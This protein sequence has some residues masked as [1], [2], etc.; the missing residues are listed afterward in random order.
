MNSK[1]CVISLCQLPMRAN[2]ILPVVLG[3]QKIFQRISRKFR[4]F[5]NQSL[6]RRCSSSLPLSAT[7]LLIQERKAKSLIY[8]FL[9]PPPNPENPIIAAMFGSIPSSVC[10]VEADATNCFSFSDWSDR[11]S[12]VS[13]RAFCC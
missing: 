4:I 10:S 13:I 8:R 3:I 5:R 9:L 12:S 1:N 11:S 6:E 2:F 7:C